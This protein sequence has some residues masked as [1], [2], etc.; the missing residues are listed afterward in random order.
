M[1]QFSE[2][3]EYVVQTR[4]RVDV[5]V[6]YAGMLDRRPDQA[7]YDFWVGRVGNDPNSLATLITG[8]YTSP[9]YADRVTP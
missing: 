5:I 7:G 6:T 2:S 8:F 4:A 9:E 1:T 3:P